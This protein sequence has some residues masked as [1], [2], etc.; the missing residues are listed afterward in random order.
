MGGYLEKCKKVVNN[1]ALCKAFLFMSAVMCAIV[2]APV[3]ILK[4]K[5]PHKGNQCGDK[6]IKINDTKRRRR[7][8]LNIKKSFATAVVIIAGVYA[9]TSIGSN[10]HI[11]EFVDKLAQDGKLMTAGLSLE[12]GH[13]ADDN[14][15]EPEKTEEE[16][17]EHNADFS[18]DVSFP[19]F[20]SEIVISSTEKTEPVENNIP[21]IV[22]TT[23]KGG[24]LITNNT[25]YEL[26][27]SSLISAGTSVRLPAEGPQILIIHTHGSEAY[28]P[29]AIDSYEPSDNFR[30]ED[31]NYNVIRVGDELTAC[32]ESYGLNVIHDR[33]IYDSPSYM[34]SY[35]RSG[36]AV[37]K[38]LKEYPGISVVIDLHRDA[39]GNGDVVYK[40]VAEADGKSCSQIMLLVGTGENGLEHPNWRENLKFALYLQS[41]V[42]SKYPTLLRPIALKK[43]RYNQQLTTGSL[44][45]EVGSSGNSLSEALNAIRLFADAAAP[46][47]K[48]LSG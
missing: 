9:A 32:F 48:E 38:Y 17:N 23:I 37:E 11:R 21:A 13:N 42:V 46:A 39:I 24:M 29:D 44:I 14:S 8:A 6:R 22:P 35:P 47:L 19:P 34:G 20:P 10:P 36:E 1:F 12:L 27:M 30:T 3:C 5:M 16:K 33:N 40:T 18:P 4:A 26:D 25:S 7:D 28:T 31:K 15:D 2:S 45:L 43:E 41:S